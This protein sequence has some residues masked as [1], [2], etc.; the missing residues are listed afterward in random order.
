MEE[1]DRPKLQHY[2]NVR[3]AANDF[4]SRLQEQL[5]R[6]EG[7]AKEDLS[8]KHN[9][10]L[11]YDF[12][13]AARLKA[14]E[15]FEPLIKVGGA[16]V[17]SR[18]NH[19]HKRLMQVKRIVKQTPTRRSMPSWQTLFFHAKRLPKVSRKK[20]STPLLSRPITPIL[21]KTLQFKSQP[22]R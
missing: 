15:S 6:L 9:S 21:T 19:Q 14:W 11:A 3:K 17:H 22:Y 1:T 20:T 12:E 4:R 10:L 7:G 5:E 2:L 18:R 8:R 13:A 16:I